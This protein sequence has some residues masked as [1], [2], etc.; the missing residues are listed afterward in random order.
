VFLHED[1]PELEI[2]YEEKISKNYINASHISGP[3]AEE[4]DNIFIATQGPLLSTIETFWRMIINKNIKLIIMLS[5]IQ[6]EGRNK[7][8][9]YWPKKTDTPLVFETFKI[10]LESEDYILENA[11]IQRNFL[12]HNERDNTTYNITQLHIVCWCDHSAPEEE[13]GYKMIDLVLSYVEDFRTAYKDS[14]VV[15]HCRYL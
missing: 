2:S 15:V 14:P 11:V 9:M 5:N 4:D 7:C 6:E 1:K 13:L 8:D 3:I 10:H 12:I